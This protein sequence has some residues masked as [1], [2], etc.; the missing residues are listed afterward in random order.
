MAFPPYQDAAS[1][2]RRTL[3]RVSRDDTTSKFLAAI[4]GTTF[5]AF[6]IGNTK[7]NYDD[8]EG[9]APRINFHGATPAPPFDIVNGT[10][11]GEVDHPSKSSMTSLRRK[12]TNLFLL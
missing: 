7:F 6:S 11:F 9:W 10:N 8:A 3:L 1:G 5:A 2:D 12:N 4:S